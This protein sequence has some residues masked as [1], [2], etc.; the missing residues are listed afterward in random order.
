MLNE[1]VQDSPSIVKMDTPV[2]VNTTPE[3]RYPDRERKLPGH[4][5]SYKLK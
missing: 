2:K 5:A 1:C 3:R 4:L